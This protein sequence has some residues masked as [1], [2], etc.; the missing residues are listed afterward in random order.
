MSHLSP[1]EEQVLEELLTGLPSVAA[2]RLG[3][4][5]QHVATI[6]SRVRRKEAK[7]KKFLQTLKKYRRV[8]HPQK[9]YKG[10]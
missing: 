5:R 2:L 6:K 1:K 3:I 7:A 10:I 8:L 9:Q 4:S